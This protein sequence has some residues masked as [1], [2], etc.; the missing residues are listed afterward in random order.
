MNIMLTHNNTQ[1][2]SGRVA[3]TNRS[4]AIPEEA[5]ND[6]KPLL[7]GKGVP[8]S[9]RYGS[10]SHRVR[11]RMTAALPGIF[12]T[13]AARV[14]C[15]NES[16]QELSQFWI[17]GHQWLQSYWAMVHGVPVK[18]IREAN[19]AETQKDGAFDVAQFSVDENDAASIRLALTK[20]AEY[21]AELQMVALSLNAQLARI[22]VAKR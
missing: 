2:A 12:A 8:R 15:G 9:H 14:E 3:V 20:L 17:R 6:M 16:L 1:P 13:F 5:A 22:T 10:I 19:I 18:S 4:P 21:Q 11:Y 7:F